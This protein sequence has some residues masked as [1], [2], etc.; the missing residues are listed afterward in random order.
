MF[1]V[2]AVYGPVPARTGFIRA[3]LSYEAEPRVSCFAL[4]RTLR[5][6]GIHGHN[7]VV[8]CI[9]RIYS[10]RCIRQS[11]CHS[12]QTDISGIRNRIAGSDQRI[13]HI[14]LLFYCCVFHSCILLL[15]SA[16]A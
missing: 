13:V 6:A 14:P 16:A 3:I 5:I 15:D 10:K 12:A 4:P 2:D 7:G 1:L 11:A 9:L 8:S